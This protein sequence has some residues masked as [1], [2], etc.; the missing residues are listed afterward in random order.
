MLKNQSEIVFEEAAKRA[1][2]QAQVSPSIYKGRL[3]LFA[4]LGYA[5][6]FAIL[7]ALLAIIGGLGWLA[8]TSTSA[9]L[10]LL[11]KKKLIIFIV[12][13]I[14]V[15]VKALWVRFE[16]PEGYE[17]NRIQAPELFNELDALQKQLKT[18]K[19]HR[20]LLTPEFNASIAQTPQLG[21]F[22]W[23]R[24]T[25]TL[26]LELLLVLSQ[27]QA[28]AVIAHE[29]G[30]LS[31]NHSRFNSWIYRARISWGNIMDAFHH[32]QSW[33]A[34]LMRRFFDWY[35]PR[36]AAYSFALA[37][38]NEYEADAISAELTSPEDAG[39]ALVCAYVTSPYIDNHY[40]DHFFKEADTIP[41]PPHGPW[42][43]LH[44]FL[45]GH[46]PVREKLD[47]MLEKELQIQTAYHNTHP[48]L[49]DRVGAIL[50]K[51]AELSVRPLQSLQQTAAYNW[52]GESYESIIKS[53]DDDWMETFRERWQERYEYVK[54]SRGEL[55]ALN[56]RADDELSDE[57]LWK[58]ARLIEEFESGVAALSYY[59]AYQNR[60]PDD[61]D[62]GLVIGRILYDMDDEELLAQMKLALGRPAHVIEA[63]E[64]AYYYLTR[65]ERHEEASWWKER[66]EVQMRIDEES[67]AERSRLAPEDKLKASSIDGEMRQAIVDALAAH[68]KVK[69][70]WLAEKVMKHYPEVPA[71]AIAIKLRGFLTDADEVED[72][73]LEQLDIGASI[74]I[75]PSQGEYKKLAKKI[76]KS[77][78]RI[79]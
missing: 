66:A 16:Q 7:A 10:I 61:A 13:A 55:A 12:P 20:V 28:R 40:W 33:G 2:R 43:G 5:V 71:I 8:A 62:A 57:E 46:E 18:P 41:V 67:D 39:T 4:M 63:C 77:G 36:F 65:H 38:S 29:L 30:H 34:G 19:I 73:L 75:V 76:I 49:V 47:E 1:E 52:L 74:F 51:N 54:T 69:S 56:D 70:A 32:Q 72:E 3:L 35:A 64:Y 68:P 15:L 58:Q 17:L 48:A 22:G 44:C 11:L 45:S 6:I 59:R 50:G 79:V 24:N 53:F 26:G 31:G 14:W 23:Q 27:E 21:I 25:L 37:R 78:E 42:Q 9:L 60:Q